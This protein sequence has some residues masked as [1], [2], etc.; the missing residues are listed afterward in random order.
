MSNVMEEARR[1][2]AELEAEQAGPG[3]AAGRGGRP[4]PMINPRPV[5]PALVLWSAAL[6]ALA[7]LWGLLRGAPAPLAVPTAAPTVQA[8]GP[9]LVDA[10]TTT[11]GPAE[12]P[13][14]PGA[15]EGGGGLVAVNCSAPADDAERAACSATGSAPVRLEAPGAAPR[16]ALA[17][18]APT[19][20]DLVPI[21]PTEAPG[22]RPPFVSGTDPGATPLPNFVTNPEARP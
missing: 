6:V 4:A 3:A 20:A 7:L 9:A 14:A 5:V 16:P 13:G 12:E 17:Q 2:R 1:R 19:P 15:A 10:E 11:T 22:W 18:A 8:D 21:A